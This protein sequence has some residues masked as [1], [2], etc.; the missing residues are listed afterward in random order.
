MANTKNDEEE[1]VNVKDGVIQY[2]KLGHDENIHLATLED[3]KDKD[4]DH[5]VRPTS[6]LMESAYDAIAKMDRLQHEL[7]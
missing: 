7:L 6:G 3:S 1:D 5:L 2:N 4:Q